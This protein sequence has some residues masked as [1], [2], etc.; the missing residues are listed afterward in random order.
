MTKTLSA[1]LS[2]II[3]FCI[4]AIAV[5][6]TE[7]DFKGPLVALRVGEQWTDKKCRYS[8]LIESTRTTHKYYVYIT[9]GNQKVLYTVDSNN[10]IINRELLSKVY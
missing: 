2:M 7:V 9:W 5:M 3:V 8:D 10:V 4:V 6:Q 1:I